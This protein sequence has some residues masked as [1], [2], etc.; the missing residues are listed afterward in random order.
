MHGVHN[1]QCV[2]EE[3]Q[4]VGNAYVDGDEAPRCNEAVEWPVKIH[5]ACDDSH[6]ALPHP[7]SKCASPPSYVQANSHCARWLGAEN[8]IDSI[9]EPVVS[10]PPSLLPPLQIEA[11]LAVTVSFCLGAV[12][13]ALVAFAVV[14][15]PDDASIWW[16]CPEA[17]GERRRLHISNRRLWVAPSAWQRL[18]SF[19]HQPL[20][21]HVIDWA[22]PS[23]IIARVLVQLIKELATPSSHRWVDLVG[24]HIWRKTEWELVWA[25]QK[26]QFTREFTAPIACVSRRVL[27]EVGEFGEEGL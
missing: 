12:D 8:I 2:F 18:T 26:L 15:L 17:G 1:V 24:P 6:I 7:G 3:W 16:S 20:R 13:E 10:Q 25:H 27:T 11:V 22:F 19:E 23:D 5:C 21:K 9:V 14:R 4:P